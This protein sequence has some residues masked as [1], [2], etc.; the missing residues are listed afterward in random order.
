MGFSES[1]G[2]MSVRRVLFG[3]LECRVKEP[4]EV[5]RELPL[6]R[7]AGQSCFMLPTNSIT[8]YST[9]YIHSCSTIRKQWVRWRSYRSGF[10]HIIR[11]QLLHASSQLMAS[12]VP[13]PISLSAWVRS[14][15]VVA[16]FEY[17]SHLEEARIRIVSGDK[18]G[19]LASQSH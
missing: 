7:K 9:W 14:W 19:S 13:D 4:R 3:W 12:E 16:P 5:R 10:I 18:Q 2:R 6:R 15:I 17:P 1:W 11:H 8:H